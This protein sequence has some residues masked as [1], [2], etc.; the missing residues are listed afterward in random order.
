MTKKTKLNVVIDANWF[1]SACINKNSRRVLYYKILKNKNLHVY[2][3]DELIE[4][5]EGVILREKFR[6]FISNNQVTRFKYLVLLLMKRTEIN[7]IPD[8]SRDSNDNYLLGICESCHADILIT[9]DND[10]L[11][12]IS[13]KDTLILTMGQFLNMLDTL[14]LSS[15]HL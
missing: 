15:S 8:V 11:T 3:S 6:K 4:E 13:Y 9:G 2:Y 14:G 7:D 12:L 1:I 5:F 10:L